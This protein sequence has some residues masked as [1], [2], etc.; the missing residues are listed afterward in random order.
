[1]EGAL[2]VVGHPARDLRCL[3]ERE[4]DFLIEGVV[5]TGRTW[6]GGCDCDGRGC[7]VGWLTCRRWAW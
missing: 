7:E 2:F 4:G 5:A 3:E 6:E 1:M